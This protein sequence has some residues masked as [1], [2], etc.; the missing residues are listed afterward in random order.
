MTRRIMFVAIMSSAIALVLFLVPLAIAVL[1]LFLADAHAN[2]ERE[3]LQA[4]VVIDP[5]FSGSDRTEI[6]QAAS[7]EELGLY[8]S[9][10][11]LVAGTG[12]READA[13]VLRVLAGKSGDPSDGGRMTVVVPVAS[14]E[15]ITGAVRASIPLATVWQRVLIAWLVMIA[16]AAL[17]LAV[18]VVAARSLARKITR[19]IDGLTRASN[20][21]GDGDFAVRTT[22]SGLPEI[23][24]A[25]VA[26]NATAERLG[27]LVQRERHLA[28]NASHQLRTPLTGL[29]LVLEN[30][31]SVPEADL[32]D[33]VGQ[34][35][36]RADGLEATIDELIALS[37]HDGAGVPLD[38]AAQLD[39]AEQRWHGVLGAAGR[40]LRVEIESGLPKPVVVAAA[41][42]QILDVLLENA[43]RHGKGEVTLR[44]R[45]AQGAVAFDVE[46]EGRGA[47]GE[48]I[49][50]HGVSPGG[51]SGIG[52]ALARQLASDQDG[53]L[54]LSA[55]TSHT[56][57][58]LILPV[59]DEG[60]AVA[61]R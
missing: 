5:T 35:I 34:A 2:L 15:T 9:S 3:V 29:R 13:A 10:G 25:A 41:L 54:L 58:T 60:P 38:A 61:D 17:A 50:R 48:K 36:E 26:L 28:A 44:A 57:F 18:G 21:L 47:L 31:L 40:P 53:R 42:Q 16:A 32:R 46:D 6:P 11:H 56:R 1:N 14:A 23:D 37:R 59:S 24:R 27:D 51:G 43:M 45:S 39:A 8:G 4:A 20:A 12:P 19:P 52:L 55:R 30:A 33:A 22:P 7:G 49:F